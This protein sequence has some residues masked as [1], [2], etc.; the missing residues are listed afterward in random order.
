MPPTRLMHSPAG[1][2]R[3]IAGWFR[4]VGQLARWGLFATV[5]G[6]LAGAARCGAMRR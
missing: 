1:A 3:F 4:G 6:R 5:I 2:R